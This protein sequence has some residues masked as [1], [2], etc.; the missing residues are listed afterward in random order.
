MYVL[1]SLSQYLRE[2][3]IGALISLKH[4]MHGKLA[5]DNIKR[6]LLIL[7]YRNTLHPGLRNII[8]VFQ[9]FGDKQGLL[10]H[11]RTDYP[12]KFPLIGCVFTLH[13]PVDEIF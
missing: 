9:F 4:V 7:S 11:V 5:A 3:Q 6:V 1:F 2:K 10:A 12:G 13:K 8:K